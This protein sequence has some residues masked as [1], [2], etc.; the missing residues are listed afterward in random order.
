[1]STGLRG[2][3]GGYTT[4]AMLADSQPMAHPPKNTAKVCRVASPA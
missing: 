4:R 1:M 2:F 3:G